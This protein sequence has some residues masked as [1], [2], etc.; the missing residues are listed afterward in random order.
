MLT[1]ARRIEKPFQGLFRTSL[2][3][4]E[5]FDQ[6]NNDGGLTFIKC[7]A[8]G[9]EIRLVTR[10]PLRAVLDERP[11]AIERPAYVVLRREALVEEGIMTPKS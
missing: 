11:D 8:D 3:T 10:I 6:I 4:R 9:V 1:H 2:V 5:E 7:F